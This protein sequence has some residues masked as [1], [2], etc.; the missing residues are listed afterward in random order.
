MILQNTFVKIS[1]FEKI[2]RRKQAFSWM[3]RIA[4][5]EAIS[6]IN[7]KPEKWNFI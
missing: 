4:T 5:N 2:Q 7:Q 1:T 6:F 3:Y